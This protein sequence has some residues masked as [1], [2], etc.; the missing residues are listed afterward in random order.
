MVDVIL[1]ATRADYDLQRHPTSLLSLGVLGWTQQLNYGVTGLLLVAS[2]IGLRAALRGWGGSRSAPVLIGLFG[3]TV[4][5]AGIF[6]TDPGFGY[7]PGTPAPAE[8]TTSGALNSLF[9]LLAFVVSLPGA[10][11]ILGRRFVRWGLSGWG[12]YSIATGFGILAGFVLA[13]ASLNEVGGLPNLGGLVLRITIVTG[14]AWLT[15]V[16]LHLMTSLQSRSEAHAQA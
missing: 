16:S 5:A 10:C 9:D 11:F 15:L 3:I 13:I 12:W 7:P 4:V 6:V 2:A 8:P 14:F 1:G